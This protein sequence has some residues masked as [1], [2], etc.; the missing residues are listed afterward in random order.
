MEIKMDTDN[1]FGS[2]GVQLTITSLQPIN[3]LDLHEQPFDHG[4][5]KRLVC[6]GAICQATLRHE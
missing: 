2:S 1:A 4:Q 6:L 3:N 5:K